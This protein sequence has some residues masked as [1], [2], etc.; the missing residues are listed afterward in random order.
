MIL[1]MTSSL[2]DPVSFP[3][4]TTYGLMPST[5][6]LFLQQ[7]KNI[8]FYK[9]FFNQKLFP[10]HQTMR[11]MLHTYI[12]QYIFFFSLFLFPLN[13][14]PTRPRLLKRKGGMHVAQRAC[15]WMS[16]FQKLSNRETK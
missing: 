6:T 12:T 2:A 11:G 9:Y 7:K 16:V 10:F 15:A 13:K 5:S 8:F 1:P 3:H 4:S 14:K